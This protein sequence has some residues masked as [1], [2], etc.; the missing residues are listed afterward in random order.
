MKRKLLCVALIASFIGGIT[1]DWKEVITP[2]VY[3]QEPEEPKVV[4][5]EVRIDWNEARIEK[6]IQEKAEHYNVSA[7]EMNRV[8]QC[9]STG[10]TTIQSWQIQ[11]YGRELSFGLVQ[12]HL[13]AHPNITKEQAI[14]PT[15]AIDFLAKNFAEGRHSMWSCY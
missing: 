7:S 14:D 13:P 3:A 6:E 9:E 5:I 1:H 8:I 12:I 10:S 15:F 11:P 2:V 4:Q